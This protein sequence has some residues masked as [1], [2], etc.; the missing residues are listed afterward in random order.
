MGRSLRYFIRASFVVLAVLLGFSRFPT[1]GLA[2]TPHGSLFGVVLSGPS[3]PAVRI[4]DP[5]PDRPLATEVEVLT[6]SG[7]LVTSVTSDDKGEFSVQLPAGDYLVSV[8]P[9][10]K[11][12]KA[13]AKSGQESSPVRINAGVG[14]RIKLYVD[15]G[16]R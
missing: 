10:V 12:A 16:I 14:T 11:S 7:R 15:T 4:D 5:C 2:E 13:F 1:Q 6:P 8:A 9:L 3:C